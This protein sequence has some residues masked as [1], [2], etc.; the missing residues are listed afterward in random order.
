MW[1]KQGGAFGAG[2][3][4]F[5]AKGKGLG[6]GCRDL[7]GLAKILVEQQA[8]QMLTLARDMRRSEWQIPRVN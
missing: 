1:A 4:G 2:G 8:K 5:G 6:E 3:G 7:V